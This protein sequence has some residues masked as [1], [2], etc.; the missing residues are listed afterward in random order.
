[1]S[2]FLRPVS[3]LL[4]TAVCIAQT[5]VLGASRKAEI[6]RML[7]DIYEKQ[8]D[9]H[10]AMLEYNAWA[11]CA[12]NDAAVHY[13]FGSYL[14]RQRQ[15]PIA[16]RELKKAA[17]LDP[18]H[19]EYWVTLGNTCL[20]NKNYAGAADAFGK[21]GPQYEAKRKEAQDY[22]DRIKAINK[23]NEQLKQQQENQ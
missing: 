11:Q 2:R 18:S 4:L 17:S 9:A 15:Y 13:S 19:V 10:D 22:I 1:M 3:L 8:H 7:A 12:P 5:S 14:L 23:Y 20:Y 16:E 21:A 6:H